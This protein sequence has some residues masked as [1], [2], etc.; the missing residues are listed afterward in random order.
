MSA[1]EAPTFKRFVEVGRVVLVND[2]PSKGKLAAIVEIIDHARALIDGPETGVPRQQIAY[3]KVVL[4]PYVL[5]KLPRAAR[6]GALSKVWKASGVEEKWAASAWNKKRQ[7]K[8]RR[9]AL[10]DFERFKVQQLKAQRS[11]VVSKE[12]KKAKS[13]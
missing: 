5:K 3:R 6:S 4:T 8:E 12:L 7:I 2:G 9:A 11:K 10:T 1:A 13:S